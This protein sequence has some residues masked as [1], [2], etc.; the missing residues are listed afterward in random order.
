MAVQRRDPRLDAKRLAELLAD[1]QQ[2]HGTR[3]LGWLVNGLEAAAATNSR[4][5]ALRRIREL[6]TRARKEREADLLVLLEAILKPPVVA[7]PWLNAPGE[8]CVFCGENGVRYLRKANI[9]GRPLVCEEHSQAPRRAHALRIIR[10]GLLDPPDE[11]LAVISG[12]ENSFL[13]HAWETEGYKNPREG[14]NHTF[15]HEPLATSADV[16]ALWQRCTAGL[17]AVS[18]VWRVVSDLASA[19][20]AEASVRNGQKGG[21]RPR[22]R[23]QEKKIVRLAKRGMTQVAIAAQLGTD[24]SQVSRVLRRLRVL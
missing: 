3:R 19:R 24:Q 23:E 21:G 22:D 16:L 13:N 7:P 18:S 11:F 17:P 15:A 20:D 8:T 4:A 2:R 6:R 9:L 5:H 1:P 14:W 10:A 12:D